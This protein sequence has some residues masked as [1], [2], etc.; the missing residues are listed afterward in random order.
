MSSAFAAFIGNAAAVTSLRAT[1]AA[2]RPAHAYL[3]TGPSQVGKRTLAR[4]LAATLVCNVAD[5]Q[6]SVLGLA[7][8]CGTCRACVLGSKDTHPDVRLVEPEA[9]KR[10][11][12]IEQ[13][14]QLEHAVGLR[15]Y[16]ATRKVFIITGAD[17]LP[18]PA[19][20]ALLKTLEEPPGDTIL[21]LTA[22]DVSQVLPTIASRCREVAL[23]P[24]PVA[25]ITAALTARGAGESEAVRLARLAGGRPGWALAA[26]ADPQALAARSRHVALL[27][28][29]LAQ[30]RIRRLQ[31]AAGFSE[32][33][34]TKDVLDLWLGWWRDALLVQ[35]GC[36]DLAANVDRLPEIERLAAVLPTQSVW[37]A[38]KRIQETRQQL[39]ANVNVR[40][41]VEALLLDLPEDLP[42]RVAT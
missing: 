19:A 3:L 9:G 6:E 32:V 40:L 14:R 16:E 38:V 39:D 1:L 10:G 4:A 26:M 23:R 33:A 7:S 22:S 41:A 24:V 2:G 28:T 20:N 18:E 27:E 15:P 37:A 25:E 17:A 34:I 36:A 8:P 42:E 11:V 13:V 5:P 29:L 30:P 31:A 35:H 21:V 12:T